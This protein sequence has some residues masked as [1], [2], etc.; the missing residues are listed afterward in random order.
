[1]QLSLNNRRTIEQQGRAFAADHPGYSVKEIVEAYQAAWFEDPTL[2][3]EQV[4]AASTVL[5]RAL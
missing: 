3:D 4:M 1:M 5:E 2:T